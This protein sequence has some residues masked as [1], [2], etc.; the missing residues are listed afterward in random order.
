[1][2][3]Y[4]AASIAGGRQYLATYQEMVAFLKEQGHVIL[5]EHIVAPDVWHLESQMSPEQI[6]T[7]DI[8]WLT[9]ADCLIAEVSNPSLGVGYEIGYALSLT[10]P[11]LCLYHHEVLLSRMIL[12]N[13]RPGLQVTAYQDERDW[14]SAIAQFLTTY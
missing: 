10:K 4:F 11:V 6:Y 12:G 3:I 13:T 9:E 8:Q 14:R 5:T 2:Q 7:R 1:M